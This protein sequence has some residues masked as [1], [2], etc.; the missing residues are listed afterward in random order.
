MKKKKN[1]GIKTSSPFSK[2][3]CQLVESL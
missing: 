3:N 1:T 2:T